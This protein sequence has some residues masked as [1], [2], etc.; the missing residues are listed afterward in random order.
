[1][2][3]DLTRNTFQPLK[4]FTR[5]L[6]Q[7]GRVQLDADWNEQSSILLRQIH[8]LGAD[9][10]GDH[11][12]PADKLGF[13]IVELSATRPG[14]VDFQ[15][16]DGDYYV[17]G[18]LCQVETT[19]IPVYPVAAGT[20]N[21]NN[22]MQVGAWNPDG[23]EFKAGQWVNFFDAATGSGGSVMAITQADAPSRTLTFAGDLSGLFRS[24]TTPRLRRL[25]TYQTQPD[26]H[27]AE[28][29]AAGRYQV[30]LDVWER[31]ITYV[32]DDSIREVALDGPDTA[33]RSHLAAQ[34]KIMKHDGAGCALMSDIAKVF[35][36]PNRGMLKAKAKQA[37][38]STDPCIIPPQ[39]SYRGPE[40]QLYRVEIHTGSFDATGKP[41]TPTFKW[42][43]ENGAVVFP[44]V[45][46]GGT[47][48]LTLANLGRDDRFGLAEGDWVEM[49]DDDYVLQMRAGT[50]MQVQGIDRTTMKVT[51]L[52]APD[53][54]IG[55]DPAKHPL[56]RRWDQ[57]EGDPADGGLQLGPDNAAQ[58]VE[59]SGDNW[60][61]LEDGV[62]IQFQKSDP[63][64][65]TVYRT[66]DYWLIP[67]R[68]A[69]GDVEW[70]NDT[71]T[72][73]QGNVTHSPI[74]REPDGVTHHYAPLAIIT[75]GS[76][77][78]VKVTTQCQK[79]YNRLTTGPW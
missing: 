50:L 51:L 39:A 76:E 62:Q 22:Q 68:T 32:E 33:A 6:M 20:A 67:A 46:G 49:Q 56:L 57:K 13:M 43:R 52:G 73:A 19:A 35:Q 26:Y 25:V 55:K 59:D 23:L 1:M 44:I 66:G 75:V 45:S 7:Q 79:P 64:H 65:P 8:R 47:N 60:L 69:T 54:T 2:K 30:Y 71:V 77:G 78:S 21:A 24:Y 40:N 18:I 12:G 42:S 15:I 36:P 38:Q 31:L 70:P 34:V 63:A 27:P 72:D 4:H 9:I 17:D 28:Q 29:A 11:G 41:A 5:V 37:A 14:V 3:A 48:V 74:A 10:I 16:A 53:S 61:E 58:I